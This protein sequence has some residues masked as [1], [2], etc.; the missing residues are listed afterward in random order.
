MCLF[1]NA[2]MGKSRVRS[3][4]YHNFRIINATILYNTNNNLKVIYV[5]SEQVGVTANTIEIVI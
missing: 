2:P 1:I 5:I 3:S 4:S